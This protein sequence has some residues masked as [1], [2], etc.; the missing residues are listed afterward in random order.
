MKTV[1]LRTMPSLASSGAVACG[2]RAFSRLP[3]PRRKNSMSRMRI[4]LVGG[5]VAVVAAV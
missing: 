2:V 3:P 5:L 4:A 1:Q